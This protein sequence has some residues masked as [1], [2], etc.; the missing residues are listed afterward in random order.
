MEPLR[1]RVRSNS[2]LVK[3]SRGFAPPLI[4]FSKKCWWSYVWFAV[5]MT[6]IIKLSNMGITSCAWVVIPSTQIPEQVHPMKVA[7]SVNDLFTICSLNT[8]IK[9]KQNFRSC[10]VVHHQTTH[11]EPVCVIGVSRLCLQHL[12]SCLSL[13]DLVVY[14]KRQGHIYK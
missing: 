10:V 5:C 7:D 6:K 11:F 2:C 3:P 14:N 1:S 9:M 8:V 4:P 12:F 13:L